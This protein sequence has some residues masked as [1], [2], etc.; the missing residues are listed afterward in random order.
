LL[1]R[2][3]VSVMLFWRA[4]MLC[5]AV[6]QDCVSQCDAVLESTDITVVLLN[7]TVSASVMLFWRALMSLWCS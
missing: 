5:G 3:D 6:E 2:A 4:L 1:D 7:R